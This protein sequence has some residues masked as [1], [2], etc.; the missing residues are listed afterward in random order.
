MAAY[1]DLSAP[2][3]ELL[4]YYNQHQDMSLRWAMI[5]EK[6]APAGVLDPALFEDAPTEVPALNGDVELT[7]V[8]V[9]DSDGKVVLDDISV[10][11]PA[12][13][14]IAISAQIG[15]DRR[16]LSDV[17]TRELLPSSGK[18]MIADQDMSTLHQSVVAARIGH[19][20]S[21]P[22][23]FSGTYGENILMPLRGHPLG[24][25][26]ESDI[27]RE[28]AITGNSCLLYTSPSPRD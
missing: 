11:L 3:K 9:R 25:L 8:S 4:A 23:L 13:R 17:L 7:G 16:A 5:T 21:R 24:A 12:G 19:A 6:F 26:Q 28:S 10:T 18:V 22:V 2:W 15:E 27:T 14:R 1:K 20:S